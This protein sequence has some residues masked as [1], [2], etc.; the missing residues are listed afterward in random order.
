MLPYGAQS[1]S[2]ALYLL[3]IQVVNL[4]RDTEAAEPRDHLGGLLNGLGP[5]VVGCHAAVAAATT[6]ADDC[7]SRL[8]E[9][10]GDT[11]ATPTCRAGYHCDLAAQ[12][13]LVRA[14]VHVSSMAQRVRVRPKIMIVHN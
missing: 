2:Q 9:R 13:I 11:A 3:R 8:A 1:I 10:R 14:P 12:R 7:R 5:V 6:G 4:H